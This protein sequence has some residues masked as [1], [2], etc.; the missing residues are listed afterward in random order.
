VSEPLDLAKNVFQLHAV[1]ERGT[2]AVRKTL[3]RAEV[4]DFFFLELAS[5]V[6]CYPGTI[7]RWL[8][9]APEI[10]METGQ[11]ARKPY[12]LDHAEQSL[13]FS[14]LAPP[15]A[16]MASFAVNT[17]VRDQEL[18]RLQWGVG[19]PCVVPGHAHAMS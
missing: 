3:K 7:L 6:W 13:L 19:T 17:G 10:L 2:L 5:R 15:L 14:E 9:R 11:R 16:E 12:P 18:C 8:E 1:N 4:I